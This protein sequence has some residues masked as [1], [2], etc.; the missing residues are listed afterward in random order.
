MNRLTRSL[1]VEA[2][3]GKGFFDEANRSMDAPETKKIIKRSMSCTPQPFVKRVVFISTPH[4][5]SFAAGRWIIQFVGKLMCDCSL[6]YA[7]QCLG[8]I[9]LDTQSPSTYIRS[10]SKRVFINRF[11]L[12][13]M[14]SRGQ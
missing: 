14:R 5:G 7:P 12:I 2:N 13:L 8:C 9:C 6:R 10:I 1:L 3:T 4:H 11:I